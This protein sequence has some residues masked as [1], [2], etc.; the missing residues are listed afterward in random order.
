[1]LIYSNGQ[2]SLYLDKYYKKI[3]V[4]V[5]VPSLKYQGKTWYLEYD[6]DTFLF[7]GAKEEIN[8]VIST[9]GNASGKLIYGTRNKIKFEFD[10][11]YGRDGR[12]MTVDFNWPRELIFYGEQATFKNGSVSVYVVVAFFI[13]FIAIFN[14]CGDCLVQVCPEVA[15]FVICGGNVVSYHK[16]KSFLTICEYPRVNVN[17]SAKCKVLVGGNSCIIE[18]KTVSTCGLK[19]TTVIIGFQS[20]GTVIID[21]EFVITGFSGRTVDYVISAY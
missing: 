11:I 15:L 19:L 7:N 10:E 17:S 14:L 5:T 1:M 9:N 16:T 2:G 20:Y 4:E 18:S 3:I 6:D 8:G 13:G 12:G 21:C